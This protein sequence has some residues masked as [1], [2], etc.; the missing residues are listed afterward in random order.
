MFVINVISV[1]AVNAQILLEDSDQVGSR[2]HYFKQISISL[3]TFETI[4]HLFKTQLW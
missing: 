1:A 3:K 4:P 2:V